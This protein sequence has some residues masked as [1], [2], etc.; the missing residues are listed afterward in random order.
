[1]SSVHAQWKGEEGYIVLDLCGLAQQGL[2]VRQSV[3]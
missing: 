3:F 2:S 1:M